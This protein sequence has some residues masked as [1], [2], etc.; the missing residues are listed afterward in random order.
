MKMCPAHWQALRA[1]IEARG[2]SHLVSK[3][4]AEAKKKL[5]TEL[6]GRGA[7]NDFDPL[8]CA[9]NML[10]AAGLSCG[11]LAMLS[12]DFCPVCKAEE[13][14]VPKGEWIEGPAD[15]VLKRARDEGLV[16]PHLP[17]DASHGGPTP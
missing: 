14:G 4:G 7:E 12:G 10:F 8:L 17:P 3:N 15:A 5:A 16:P 6:E 2:L 11:G 13:N 1:A 9:N